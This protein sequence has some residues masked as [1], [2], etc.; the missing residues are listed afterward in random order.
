[1]KEFNLE[2]ALAG[3]PVITRNGELV[4]QITK[5]EDIINPYCLCGKVLGNIELFTIDG[6]FSLKF[7][8]SQFD[9][10]MDEEKKTIWI[11]VWKYFKDGSVMVT[12][13]AHNQGFTFDSWF[14]TKVGNNL[15]IAPTH[16]YKREG[17]VKSSLFSIYS[18]LHSISCQVTCQVKLLYCID[19]Q[20]TLV[21]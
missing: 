10:F 19:Y 7:G 21:K 1:M 9:L 3:E 18:N 16:R 6:V 13:L 2:K 14:A 5:F 12:H 17:R 11:N 15:C 4:T 20:L 8:E